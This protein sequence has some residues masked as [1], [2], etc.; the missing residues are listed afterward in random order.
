M[1]LLKSHVYT[2]NHTLEAEIGALRGHSDDSLAEFSMIV[3]AMTSLKCACVLTAFCRQRRET[4]MGHVL[5]GLGRQQDADVAKNIDNMQAQSMLQ[6]LSQLFQCLVQDALAAA[7]KANER[8]RAQL[9][10]QQRQ[11]LAETERRLQAEKDRGTVAS[12]PRRARRVN[13]CRP[14]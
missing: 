4:E 10:Q 7:Q 2:R 11:L 3:C 12:Y 8:L 9:E 1:F 13:F 14:S 6:S 5:A